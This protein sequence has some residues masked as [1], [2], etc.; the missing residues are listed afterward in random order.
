MDMLYVFF[1]EDKVKRSFTDEDYE[2]SAG[3]TGR[4]LHFTY[5]HRTPGLFPIAESLDEVLYKHPMYEHTDCMLTEPDK[6][7]LVITI[8]KDEKFSKSTLDNISHYVEFLVANGDIPM[9]IREIFGVNA[10]NFPE[11]LLHWCIDLGMTIIYNEFGIKEYAGIAPSGVIKQDPRNS[12]NIIYSG[13]SENYEKYLVNKMV[14]EALQ[15]SF[16]NI[17]RQSII[18]QHTLLHAPRT[19]TYNIDNTDNIVNI[20]TMLSCGTHE[21]VIPEQCTEDTWRSTLFM[22]SKVRLSDEAEKHITA[23]TNLLQDYL[24]IWEDTL[25]HSGFAL[26]YRYIN[27]T[28]FIAKSVQTFADA[29]GITKT[30]EAYNSGIPLEDL[31]G[32]H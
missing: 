2:K 7:G 15:Q 27:N 26:D 17:I 3:L 21:F 13:D 12:A 1:L 4:T 31:I 9:H 18:P 8:C 5:D 25:Q 11:S 10:K 30:I 28:Q 24:H 19:D 29:F 22:R 14:A 6:C 32:M 20:A 23:E 16:V